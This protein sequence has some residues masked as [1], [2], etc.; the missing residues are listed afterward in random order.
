MKFHFL[1][2]SD[3]LWRTNYIYKLNRTYLSSNYV[4][5]KSNEKWLVARNLMHFRIHH[6]SIFLQWFTIPQIATNILTEH[7]STWNYNSTRK[8]KRNWVCK[9]FASGKT[10]NSWKNLKINSVKPLRLSPY[11]IT[12]L[13]SSKL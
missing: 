10:N 11:E 7:V 4:E 6:K 3:A 8:K 2:L 5:N 1:G 12:G 9:K 13:I